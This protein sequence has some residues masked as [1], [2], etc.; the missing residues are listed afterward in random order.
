M[1]EGDVLLIGNG[2]DNRNSDEILKAYDNELLDNLLFKTLEQLGFEK[3]NVRYGARFLN[4]RVEMYYTIKSDF[5]ISLL[6]KKVQFQK[7]DQIIVAVSYKYNDYDFKSFLNMYFTEV[8]MF[9]SEDKA[10]GL[11]LCKK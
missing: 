11:A 4:S 9:I 3:S 8:D 5:E 10:Y 1:K 2:L 6:G 7:G